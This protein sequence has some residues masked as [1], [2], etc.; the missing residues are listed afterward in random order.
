MP[1]HVVLLLYFFVFILF[2]QHLLT[3]RIQKLFIDC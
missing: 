3:K 2:K 1:V